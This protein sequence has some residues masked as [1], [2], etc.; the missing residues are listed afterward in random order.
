MLCDGTVGVECRDCGCCVMGL[1]VL[2]VGTVGA[3]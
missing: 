1:W 3:V 2:S